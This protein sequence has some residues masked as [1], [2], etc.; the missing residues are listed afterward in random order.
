MLMHSLTIV[1]DVHGCLLCTDVGRV[2]SAGAARGGAKIVAATPHAEVVINEPVAPT[3]GSYIPC[4][5]SA[6]GFKMAHL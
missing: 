5:V 6:C 3:T 1:P 4:K 2:C